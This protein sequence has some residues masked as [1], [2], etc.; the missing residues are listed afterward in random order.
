MCIWVLDKTSLHVLSVVH[1]QRPL[2]NTSSDCLAVENSGIS[3]PFA[4]GSCAVFLDSSCNSAT[5][6]FVQFVFSL[7]PSKFYCWNFHCTLV[8]HS[9]LRGQTSISK[10]LQASFKKLM[11]DVWRR[12][13]LL[14]IISR[15]KSGNYWLEGAESSWIAMRVPFS[16][17][18]VNA[19]H[20]CAQTN[21]Y[22]FDSSREREGALSFR[23]L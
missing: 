9:T 2:L 4:Y 6:C 11:L 18:V 12:K 21:E 5:S 13:I 7:K 10:P 22:Q 14:T 3:R 23:T 17:L 1:V 16:P 20:N 15:L 8:I 19:S